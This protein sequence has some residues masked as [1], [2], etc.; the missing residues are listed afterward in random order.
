MFLTIPEALGTVTTISSVDHRRKNLEINW[1][2]QGNNGG[3]P[4]ILKTGP[5]ILTRRSN[6]WW[7]I[8]LATEQRS[9]HVAENILTIKTARLQIEYMGIRKTKITV[10]GG[11][12]CISPRTG[13]G[14]F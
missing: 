7:D 1:D 10:H 13:W 14:S 3:G 8:L 9:R 11:C 2:Q 6:A 5:K 4:I 12:S